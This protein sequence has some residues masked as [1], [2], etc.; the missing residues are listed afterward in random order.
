MEDKIRIRTPEELDDRKNRFLEICKILED[1]DITYFLLG[2]VLLGAR[3]DNSFI[4]WDWDVEIC[5]FNEEFN[6]K[7]EQILQKLLEYDFKIAKC[8]KNNFDSKID[9]SKNFSKDVT[10]Y[11]IMGWSLDK[12][13]NRYFRNRISF[14]GYFLKTFGTIE[15]LGKKFNTPSPLDEYL[16]FQYDDWKIKKRTADKEKYMTNKYFKRDNFIYKFLKKLVSKIT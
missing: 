11:T 9:V 2:G 13:K 5:V 7:F 8:R 10:S 12:S 4:E 3:R 15:F 6:N 14:P 16:S 1:L